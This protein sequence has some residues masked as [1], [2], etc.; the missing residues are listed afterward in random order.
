MP[1]GPQRRGQGEAYLF[2]GAASSSG[3][4]SDRHDSAGRASQRIS[5]SAHV[6]GATAGDMAG[7]AV[8]SV[9]VINAGQPTGILIG[10][11]GYSGDGGTVYLI[12]GRQPL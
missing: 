5:D 9:G 12:P 1:A 6:R 8:S 7:Y 4:Y 10:A 11:P 2:Y 3:A